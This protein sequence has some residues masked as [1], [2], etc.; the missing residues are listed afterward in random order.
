MT[1][2][3]ILNLIDAY[4]ADYDR[5]TAM[6]QEKLHSLKMY[7]GSKT[8]IEW[9]NEEYLKAWSGAVAMV[10]LKYTIENRESN[11]EEMKEF[12]AHLGKY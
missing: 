9:A 10:A 5:L 7:N 2:K 1:K 12:K 11:E 3:E 4:A 8:E 6:A